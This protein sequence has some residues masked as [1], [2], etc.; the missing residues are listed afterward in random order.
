MKFSCPVCD[1]SDGIELVTTKK[2]FNVRGESF[3]VDV[4]YYQCPQCHEEFTDPSLP[5]PFASAYEMFRRNHRMLTPQEIRDFRHRFGLTQAELAGILGLG[6]A[7]LSRYESGRLQDE[8]HDTLLRL[9]MEPENLRTLVVTSHSL[10]DA[11]KQEVLATLQSSRDCLDTLERCITSGS[12]TRVADEFSGYRSFDR[13]RFANAVKVL[14]GGGVLKTKLNKLLFYADFLHFRDYA[15]SITGSRYA[16]IP[17]G[18]AP[19]DYDLYFPLLVRQGLLSLKEISFLGFNGTIDVTGE[20]Y[21]SIEKPDH[22][23]FSDSEL[24]TLLM[25]KRFFKDFGARKISEFSHNED[26]YSLTPAGQ[27]ISYKYAQSLQFTRHD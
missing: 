17:F 26:G 18:P 16:R 13:D 6:G 22:N 10:S 27:W 23:V 4:A 12:G 24:E 3:S 21:E 2:D 20:E 14:A 9:A 25:V 5:D 8:T 15:V 7:T 1:N 11:K 19:E